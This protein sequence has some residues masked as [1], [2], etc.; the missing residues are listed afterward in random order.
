[1]NVHFLGICGTAMGAVA[2]AMAQ[3]GYTITGSDAKV[4]PPMSDFLRE[5]GI[6]L[7]EGYSADNLPDT[8]DMFIVGNAMSRGNPEV[9]A[10]LESGK[11][12]MSLPEAMKEFF[13]WQ[14]RNFVVTG[15]HGKTTTTSMLTWLFEDGGLN[16]SFMIGGIARNL[17]RGGRFTDSRFTV[18]EGDEYD[19]A[20]F[21][22][23]SKFL[24]YLPE[25]VI[26]N[27]IEMDHADIYNNVDEI[28]L[29]F[30]RLLRVV[31]QHGLVLVN[32]DCANCMDV[33]TRAPKPVRV[34]SVGFGAHAD[35]QIKNVN[36]LS[37]SCSFELDGDR[38]NIA[39]IGEFNVRNAA[40]AAMA[41]K[42]AGLKPAQIDQSL[43]LFKGIARRQE[44]RGTVRGIKVIDDFAHH[45]TAIAQAIAALR[46]GNQGKRIWA[47]FDPRSNTSSSKL[48]QKELALSL[49]AADMAV[50]API[51]RA[52]KHAPENR[53]NL[54]QLKSDIQAT[55]KTC[56]LGQDVDDIVTHVCAQA[57]EGDVLLIMSN[58]GFGGIHLKFLSSL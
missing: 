41:A 9:E 56:Y 13:L 31:P 32:A 47:I 49:A 39:M 51:E 17:G 54:Q 34:Q 50:V 37:S 55:G 53:L 15:T 33:I 27:N 10:L 28:K 21:D 42:H 44:L 14:K 20:F 16:P 18:L 52:S 24:H 40:M 7:I 26:M 22:K 43:Q 19:T 38:Y 11:R 23:R 1:M 57:K 35:H 5:Q 25:L 48:F 2:S 3:Q 6:K 4:Y 8:A 46:Q 30:E 29:S 58:G 45:P 12:Y 36:Y